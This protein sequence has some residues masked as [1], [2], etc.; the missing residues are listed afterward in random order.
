MIAAGCLEH[1]D[2]SLLHVFRIA[3][4][5]HEK[6]FVVRHLAEPAGLAVERMSSDETPGD[7]S[8]WCR[9]RG[10]TAVTYECELAPLPA[11]WARHQDA[12]VRMLVERR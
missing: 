5:N 2:R 7:S 4:F 3:C 6:I 9:E 12:V 8:T 10:I 1:F 11:L